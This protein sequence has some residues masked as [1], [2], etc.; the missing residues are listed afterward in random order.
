MG[1]C[2]AS[3]LNV[4]E[5][6][7]RLVLVFDISFYTLFMFFIFSYLFF[8]LYFRGR[9]LKCLALQVSKEKF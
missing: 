5:S 4:S 1:R 2:I 3:Y 9:R 8:I 6:Q 7:V